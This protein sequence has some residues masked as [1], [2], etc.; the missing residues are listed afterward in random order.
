[1]KVAVVVQHL[2]ELVQCLVIT[3]A[4]L[5]VGT[6]LRQ[7]RPAHS[8]FTPSRLAIPFGVAAVLCFFRD[9]NN[10]KSWYFAVRQL[11]PKT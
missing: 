8:V 9:T 11:L 4:L 1:M 10:F 6:I 5:E 2:W 3:L 7:Q